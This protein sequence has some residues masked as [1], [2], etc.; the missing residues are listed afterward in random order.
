VP[1]VKL[2]RV[3]LMQP[4]RGPVVQMFSCVGFVTAGSDGGFLFDHVV[5]GEYLVRAWWQVAA[6]RRVIRFAAASCLMPGGEVDLGRI[7]PTEGGSLLVT[8]TLSD[9]ERTVPPAELYP[10]PAEPAAALAVELL[11]DSNNAND[12]LQEILPLPLEVQHE[13]RGLAPG[14]LRL[15]AAPAHWLHD[16]SR[17]T[18]VHSSESI[19]ERVGES[20]SQTLALRVECAVSVPIALE[21]ATDAGSVELFARRLPDGPA[22]RWHWLMPEPGTVG[23]GLPRVAALPGEYELIAR[24]PATDGMGPGR[25]AVLRVQ[26][27]R[28]GTAVRVPLRA[29]VRRVLS[30]S[31][32]AAGDVLGWRPAHWP[33]VTPLL[34]ARLDATGRAV[35]SGLFAELAW[36]GLS[37]A[38][39]LPEARPGEDRVIAFGA[40]SGR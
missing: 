17:A 19:F 5:E 28:A 10:P 34:C 38:L 37:G 39:D 11:A 21:P 32:V 16:P 36:T 15:R 24:Q 2:Y 14:S 12:G 29:G 18:R 4:S 9:G 25:A 35:L 3:E 31:A 8:L 23:Y 6:A 7:S 20:A 26:V 30:G 33:G 1:Q 40:A 27:T 22:L 13:L